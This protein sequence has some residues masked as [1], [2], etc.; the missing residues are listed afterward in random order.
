[1]NDARAEFLVVRVTPEMVWITDESNKRGGKSVT[2]DADGVVAWLLA[3][4]QYAGRR[5]VYRDTDGNWDELK[6]DGTKFVG[7]APARGFSA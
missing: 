7:F 5:I 1:M 4:S 6:H 3:H 2:N